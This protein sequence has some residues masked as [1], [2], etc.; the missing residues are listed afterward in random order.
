VVKVERTRIEQVFQN[1]L[2]NA[3]KYM[4]K[5]EGVVRVGCVEEKMPGSGETGTGFWKLY[6]ADNG[7]GIA[8]KDFQRVW[9]LFQ[10]LQPRDRA[11]STG[12]GLAVVKKSVEMYGGRVWL[13]SELGKG[14]TFWFTL[15]KAESGPAQ[16]AEGS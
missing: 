3:L 11:D 9:Q 10:T 4:D 15:P 16:K 1:F 5:P 8:E 7:P 13:E 14:S 6:V 12:V 2:S